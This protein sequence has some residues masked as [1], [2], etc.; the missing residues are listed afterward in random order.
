MTNRNHLIALIA[1]LRLLS[2]KAQA[3]GD[4]YNDKNPLAHYWYGVKVGY[5]EAANRIEVALR[6]DESPTTSAE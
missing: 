6:D 3:H 4:E 5:E 2:R 1:E